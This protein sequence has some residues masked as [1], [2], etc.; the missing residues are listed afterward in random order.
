MPTKK[1]KYDTLNYVYKFDSI[2][3]SFKNA[4]P[5]F[6]SF[7]SFLDVFRVVMR[8]SI[9]PMD[10]IVMPVFAFADKGDYLVSAGCTITVKFNAK[11]EILVYRICICLDVFR[12]VMRGSIFPTGL[13]VMPVFACADKGDYTVSVGCT[14][15]VKFNPKASCTDSFWLSD[16]L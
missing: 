2:I 9:F 6:L 11:D 8:G 15:T 10:L 13:V 12:V 4:R 16:F 5:N 1:S 14:V 7:N 3:G